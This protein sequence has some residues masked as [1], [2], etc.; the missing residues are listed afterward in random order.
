MPNSQLLAALMP[1]GEPAPVSR[2]EI[3]VLPSGRFRWH[4]Y[5]DGDQPAYSAPA[6]GADQIP[7]MLRS[8]EQVL[9]SS[10][11]LHRQAMVRNQGG[12]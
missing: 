5:S 2:I 8:T 11:E 1:N 6:V 10:L 12:N 3:E 9:A 7:G 4:L